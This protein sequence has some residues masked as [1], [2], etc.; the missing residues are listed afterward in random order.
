METSGKIYQNFGTICHHATGK[1]QSRLKSEDE[2]ARLMVPGKFA[3]KNRRKMSGLAIISHPFIVFN[4]IFILCTISAMIPVKPYLRNVMDQIG[5]EDSRIA[6]VSFCFFC[7]IPIDLIV[8]GPP[9]AHLS[10]YTRLKRTC[11]KKIGI[12]GLVYIFNQ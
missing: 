3:T 1:I 6:L 11:D 8:S 2:S 10:L 5:L 4:V 7:V 9:I 12:M